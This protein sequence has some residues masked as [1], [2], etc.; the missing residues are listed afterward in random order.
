MAKKVFFIVIFSAILIILSIGQVHGDIIGNPGYYK[1]DSPTEPE[2]KPII[3]WGEKI[4]GIIF[5]V[6]NIVSVGSIMLIGIR[7]M[8]SSVEEK[9]EYKERLLPYF[10]GACLLF[11]ATHIVNYIYTLAQDIG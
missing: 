10:I 11:V 1:P 9:A 7:Y 6:G 4:I 3:D 5:V 2:V 8:V